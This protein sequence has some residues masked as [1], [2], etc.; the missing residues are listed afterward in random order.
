MA[1]AA[2]LAVNGLLLPGEHFGAFVERL[3][4]VV[5]S[6]VFVWVASDLLKNEKLAK[7]AL[8]AYGIAAVIVAV[9]L[10]FSLPGFGVTGEVGDTRVSAI[11]ASGNWLSPI[12]AV[13]LLIM[14]GLWLNLA[15]K[16][17][18]V[19]ISMGL[20]ILALAAAIV[21][22][23]SRLGFVMAMIGVSVY[24][25]PY[26]QRRWRISSAIAATIAI[27]GLAYLASYSPV[28]SARW[29]QLVE[30]GDTGG[31]DIIFENAFGM[32]YERPLT[33]WGPIQFEYELGHRTGATH[34]VRSAF[35]ICLHVLLEVGLAGA[36][37]FLIGLWLC[38]R[39]VWKA[40]NGELGL[41]PFALFVAELA[42]SMATNSIYHK[43]LWFVLAFSASAV[44]QRQVHGMRL[45]RTPIKIA[46][47]RIPGNYS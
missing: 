3:V 15:R 46:S 44:G 21:Y 34:G 28:L 26:W 9:G 8:R 19:I 45:A 2:V 35:N 36:V 33:G 39:G 42:A 5:Q 40:R 29:E 17:L 30:E 14:L 27:A 7:E 20:S 41:L 32:L 4:S 38:G 18:V 1:Y 31:R 23:G 37:P 43:T 22:I 16:N 13:A 12:M 25:L 11:G 10:V 47:N 6:V 24:L